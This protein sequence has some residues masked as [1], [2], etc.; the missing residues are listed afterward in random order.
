MTVRSGVLSLSA[1]L[2]V[3][4]GNRTGTTVASASADPVHAQIIV[5]YDAF[6]EDSAMQKDWGYARSTPEWSA[7]PK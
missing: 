6:G 5:L 7:N 1:A 3:L 2:L 4:I